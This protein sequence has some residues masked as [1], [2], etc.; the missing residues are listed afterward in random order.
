MRLI[1]KT[2]FLPFE[3]F[4][5][6]VRNV[7]CSMLFLNRLRATTSILA[8]KVQKSWINQ[9]DPQRIWAGLQILLN[10]V[11]WLWPEAK[12]KNT[13]FSSNSHSMVTSNDYWIKGIRLV[14]FSLT[15]FSASQQLLPIYW[16]TLTAFLHVNL[17]RKRSENLHHPAL[18]TKQAIR[19]TRFWGKHNEFHPVLNND[20]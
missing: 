8:R 19:R 10:G 15:G 13:L 12:R 5:N 4:A 6:L 9:R 18:K 11:D 7:K 17:R 1:S 16:I 20:N 2:V 14:L 3:C